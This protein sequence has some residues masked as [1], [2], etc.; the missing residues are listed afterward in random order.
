MFEWKNI[1]VNSSE[2]LA[3]PIMTHSGIELIGRTVYDAVTDGEVHAMAVC[4]LGER[5]PNV[6]CSVIMD[7]TVEAEAFGSKIHFSKN[8]V[9]SVEGRLVSTIDDIQALEVPSLDKGRIKE[10]IKANRI[11][12]EKMSKP[13]ISGC[14]GPY[15]LAGR[16]Y[17]MSELMMAMFTEPESIKLLLQK[18]TDFII[19]YCKALKEVDVGGVLVAE[20]AA[21][22]LSNEFCYEFSSVYVK[23]IVDSLQDEF[24]L[25]LLHNC[26]NSGQCTEAMV[27][28][29]AAGYH[30]GNAIDMISALENCPIDSLVMGNLDPVSLF[31]MSAPLE[32]YNSTLELLNKTSGY[33]NFI[34][35]SGCDTPPE[36]PFENIE[37]FYK[38]LEDYNIQ[39]S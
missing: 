38:A 31:K 33:K 22:L 4:A 1:C 39:E 10:Y 17:D 16:L 14:I 24:F 12:V 28:T 11:I 30:F 29:G 19:S 6:A 36:I 18:C 37:N 7:L 3:L 27:A 25:V 5:Y 13:V 21:G 2:R 26:G 9:P 34:L 35:S 23:Q 32:V 8:E 15:S 20:P